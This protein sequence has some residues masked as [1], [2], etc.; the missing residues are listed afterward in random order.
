VHI[1]CRPLIG[2]ELLKSG[3]KCVKILSDKKMMVGTDREFNFD[4]IYG[5]SSSQQNIFDSSL[6]LN[7]ERSLEGYNFSAFAYGQTVNNFNIN[8]P[9]CR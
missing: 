1:R 4:M 6:K 5:E 2:A 8:L 9:G 3:Q 7:L